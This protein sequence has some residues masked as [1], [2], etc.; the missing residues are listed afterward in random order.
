MG[1]SD[2]SGGGGERENGQGSLE[3]MTFRHSLPDKLGKIM[4]GM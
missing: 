1:P 3:F 4:T 2:L